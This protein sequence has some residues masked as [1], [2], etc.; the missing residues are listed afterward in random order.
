MKDIDGMRAFSTEIDGPCGYT[1]GVCVTKPNEKIA[2]DGKFDIHHLRWAYWVVSQNA[3]RVKHKATGK[4]FMALIPFVNTMRKSVSNDSTVSFE[5]DGSV[6][7][8]AHGS[9]ASGTQVYS[10][11]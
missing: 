4:S 2:N 8:L 10:F 9:T 3:V 5:L 6:S 7:V 11:L 1:K